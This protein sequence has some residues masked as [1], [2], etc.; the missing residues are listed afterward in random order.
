MV[1]DYDRNV[2]PTRVGM[3]RKVWLMRSYKLSSPHTR[4]DGPP[5]C[6]SIPVRNAF[7]PHAWG[8][9]AGARVLQGEQQVLPT[10]VGMVRIE[11][12]RGVVGGCSPHTR[13]DGPEWTYFRDNDCKFSPHAWGWSGTSRRLQSPNGVLPTRVGMV[14]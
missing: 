9:S 7:S 12:G 14:R 10:R 6:W 11:K 1:V 4:G 13:G 8:W 5:E 2:L 3:V